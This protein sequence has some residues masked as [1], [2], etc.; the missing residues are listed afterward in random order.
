MMATTFEV[1]EL[2]NWIQQ[3]LQRTD[4]FADES[5]KSALHMALGQVLPGIQDHYPIAAFKD[6]TNQLLASSDLNDKFKAGLCVTL[7]HILHKN[8]CFHGYN[9]NYWIQKGCREWY[10]AG[11]PDFPEK[12]K[13]C[14]GPTGQQYN[15]HYY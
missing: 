13:Y 7:E 10:A 14:Y 11:Q 4:E 5:F 6:W 9:D 1:T 8:N 3:Q 12:N 15:R 2:Q